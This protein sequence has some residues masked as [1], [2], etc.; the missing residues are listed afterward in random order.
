MHVD[1]ASKF[2]ENWLNSWTGNQPEIINNF[3]F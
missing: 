3:L 2:C 1:E